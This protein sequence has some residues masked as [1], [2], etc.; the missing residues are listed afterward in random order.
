MSTQ[1]H[2]SCLGV[3][4]LMTV[5]CFLWGTPARAYT[6]SQQAEF[7]PLTS[8]ITTTLPAG[9]PEIT[10]SVVTEAVGEGHIFLTPH[11]RRVGA[12]VY[13]PYLMI[14]DNQGELIYQRNVTYTNHTRFDDF[15]LFTD[16]TIVSWVGG[17]NRHQVQN[18]DYEI[19]E[20]LKPIGYTADM[21]DIQRLPNGN[22][23]YLIYNSQR[24]DMSQVVEG[25]YS[26][27]LITGCLIQEVNPAE[28]VVF[29]WSS[30]DHFLITDTYRD[31]TTA[32]IDYVHCNAVDLD[33]DG[34]LLLSSRDLDEVTKINR[35][36]GEVMWRLGG[37][38]NQFE[39]IDAFGTSDV[40]FHRQ[41]DAR[42][43]QNGNIT[44][45]D[46]RQDGYSRVVEYQL[47]EENLIATLVWEH[48]HTP[49]IHGSILGSAQRLPNGNTLISWGTGRPSVTE[50]TRAGETVF[51]LSLPPEMVTY[52]A[53]RFPWIGRPVTTPTL[54]VD[55]SQLP[56]ITLTYSWNGATDV[57]GYKVYGGP[58]NP[59]TT[60]LAVEPKTGFETQTILTDF[61][62][63]PTHFRV[64]PLFSLARVYLPQVRR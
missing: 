8:S 64:E 5:C 29:E 19:I 24:A 58:N 34:N 45:F 10:V 17:L 9:M 1:K 59:P 32:H 49:D 48:R 18:M 15:K 40:L 51:E 20:T 6:P 61:I 43:V 23:L 38:N 12:S 11:E 26:N 47:D 39:M 33:D 60:L 52:R 31:L 36:T 13:K 28:E 46:N 62:T 22:T 57:A 14:V 56:T 27:A 4:F 37:K 16:D 7:V 3:A 25:G 35:T 30:F 21:H 41:H 50:V 44:L 63:R 42:R 55:D 53:F 54:I 2:L